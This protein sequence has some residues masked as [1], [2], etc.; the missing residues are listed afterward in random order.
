MQKK[1]IFFNGLGTLFK[2]RQFCVHELFI[3][4]WKKVF[5]YIQL[6]LVS[7]LYGWLVSSMKSI[8]NIIPS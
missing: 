2:G 3:I 1:I 5:L 8:L 7:C 6:H 4:S